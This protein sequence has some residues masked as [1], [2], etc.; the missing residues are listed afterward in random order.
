MN[1]ALLTQQQ[2]VTRCRDELGLR[3]GTCTV[4]AMTEAGMPTKTIGKRRKFH[5]E[6]CKAWILTSQELDPATL[7]TRDRLFRRSMRRTG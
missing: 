7:A 5:F 1:P 6:S 3:I 4:H 2:F